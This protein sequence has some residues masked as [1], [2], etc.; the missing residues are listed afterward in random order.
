M[1]PK[2]RLESL[3][4]GYFANRDIQ[5]TQ[6]R[7]IRLNTTGSTHEEQARLIQEQE[8]AMSAATESLTQDF[9]AVMK[10]AIARMT[11]VKAQNIRRQT[12]TAYLLARSGVLEMLRLGA[13]KLTAKQIQETVEPYR[14][15]AAAMAA[16]HGALT[17]SGWEGWK[18]KDV[19]SAVKS[20]DETVAELEKLR[21]DLMAAVTMHPVYGMEVKKASVMMMLDQW[22]G[23]LSRRG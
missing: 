15:D 19:L 4:D 22:N 2:K 13:D 7:D 20:S 16:F 5:R 21:S 17:A 8:A 11:N 10:G 14:D 6:L 3:L 9:E 18:A 1:E 12:T 23:A